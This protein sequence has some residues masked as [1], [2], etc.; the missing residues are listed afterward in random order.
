[1]MSK[2]ITVLFLATLIAGAI[3]WLNYS[4]SD[5]FGPQ[6]IQ[7][8]Y[9][10]FGARTLG[11]GKDSTLVFYL[12]KPEPIVSISVYEEKDAK[13]NQFPHPLWRLV[14]NGVPTTATEFTYGGAVAGMKPEISN[15]VPETLQPGTDYRL[16]M[17]T[18]NKIKG[19][20]TFH[21]PNN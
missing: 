19:E 17:E 21:P 4:H 11:N 12:A 6:K 13:K 14:A 20:V 7:I 9:R 18:K 8:A 10:I 1:M 16:V 5:W 15:S 2:K 3:F